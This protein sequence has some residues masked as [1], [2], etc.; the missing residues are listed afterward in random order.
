MKIKTIL[1]KIYGPFN[2]ARC[3]TM[4]VDLAT[5]ITIVT[6]TFTLFGYFAPSQTQEKL[7]KIAGLLENMTDS[8]LFVDMGDLSIGANVSKL[9]G[10]KYPE[11]SI[12]V[13]PLSGEIENLTIE[14]FEKNKHE[15]AKWE[16]GY[17]NIGGYR[18]FKKILKEKHQYMF[19][20]Y[21]YNLSSQEK[22]VVKI[23]GNPPESK[24]EDIYQLTD[25]QKPISIEG[26]DTSCENIISN[27]K[28]WKQG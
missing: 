7:I 17:I 10:E 15:I 24:N 28:I 9:H 26:N 14:A 27:L 3:R 4:L 11:L 6:G 21:R 8:D 2:A 18:T 16:A 23:V 20:C 5:F 13:A 22:I 19:I 12:I 1:H 25:L